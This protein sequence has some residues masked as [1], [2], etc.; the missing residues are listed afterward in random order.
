MISR[1]TR[2]GRERERQRVCVVGLG[3]G[4]AA[5]FRL[6]SRAFGFIYLFQPRFDVWISLSKFGFTVFS[7]LK[8]SL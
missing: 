6:Y 8:T 3:L 4:L 7:R 1:M 5:C 2:K